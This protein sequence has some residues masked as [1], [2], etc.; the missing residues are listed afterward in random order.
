M[1][2]FLGLVCLDLMTDGGSHFIHGGFRKTLAKYDV[3]PKNDRHI[4]SLVRLVDA[5]FTERYDFFEFPFLSFRVM[6]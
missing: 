1:L 2:F 5:Y 6:G 4:G 3:K